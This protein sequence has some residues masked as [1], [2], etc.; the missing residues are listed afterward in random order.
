MYLS[1]FILSFDDCRKFGIRNDYDIHQLVV[2]MFPFG[3]ERYLYYVDRSV[4]SFLKII[5]QSVTEP[6]RTAFGVM[7]SRIIPESFFDYDQYRFRVRVS[8][9]RRSEGRP[10]KILYGDLAAEWML[11]K[12]QESGFSIL[13]GSL[14]SA[15]SGIMRSRDGRNNLITIHYTDFIGVLR[16]DDRSAFMEK[17]VNSGIGPAKGFGCGLMQLSPIKD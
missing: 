5:V 4:A 3:K 9:S 14:E 16:V 7:E 12:A 13:D 1:Q 8:P 6:S 10:T 15:A 11:R 17:A 2:S